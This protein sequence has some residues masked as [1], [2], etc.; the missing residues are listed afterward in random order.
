MENRDPA[1][2]GR[3]REVA[4]YASSKGIVIGAYSLLASRG[5]ATVADNCHG[6]G[7][8]V[9]FGVMPCLGSKWGKDYLAQLKSFM[10]TTGF[11]ILEH[12]GSYPG[13][14]LRRHRSPGTPRAG[15]F[16]MDAVH[17]RSVIFTNGAGE[18][19]SI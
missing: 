8:R 3:Y 12:D 10:S 13:D 11:G 17:R 19:G 2:Q 14:T 9:H 6:P 18:M 1:Y 15:G 16:P 7:S 4:D 5:A